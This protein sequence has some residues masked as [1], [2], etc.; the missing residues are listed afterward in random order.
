LLPDRD[1]W[2]TD[3]ALLLDDDVLPALRG[4]EDQRELFAPT[5]P[6]DAARSLVDEVGFADVERLIERWPRLRLAD[7]LAQMHRFFHWELEHSDLMSERGGFD[8][9]IG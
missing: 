5:M 8:A 2:L 6:A 4:G 3:L 7:Q 9:V 1:E